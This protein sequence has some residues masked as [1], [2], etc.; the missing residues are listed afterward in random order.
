MLAF[1]VFFFFFCIFEFINDDNN[2]TLIHSAQG[3]IFV[4]LLD[5]IE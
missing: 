1:P 2:F 3:M 4:A 5:G